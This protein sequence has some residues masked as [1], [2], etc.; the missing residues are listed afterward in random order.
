[1]INRITISEFI[2]KLEEL[3]SQVGD[4]PVVASSDFVSKA[5]PQLER[6]RDG[7]YRVHIYGGG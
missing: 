4:V 7:S 5:E 2:K 6:T 1:M 3:K